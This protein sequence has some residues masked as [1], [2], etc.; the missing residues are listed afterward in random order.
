MILIFHL[1]PTSTLCD[2]WFGY[3][4]GQKNRTHLEHARIQIR[5]LYG[6][7]FPLHQD[8]QKVCQ[9]RTFWDCFMVQFVL[10]IVEGLTLAS[11]N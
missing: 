9:F 2:Q 1:V 7:I 3:S 4:E 6:C 5:L 10:V 8:F 11:S